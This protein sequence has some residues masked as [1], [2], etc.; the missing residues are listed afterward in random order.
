MDDIR[1]IGLKYE[2]M[3][4]KELQLM[5]DRNAKHWSV[6][7]GEFK[8]EYAWYDFEECGGIEVKFDEIADKSNRL[9]VDKHTDGKES[10]L[11][12]TR[13][14]WYVFFTNTRYYIIKAEILKFCC[15]YKDNIRYYSKNADKYL[16]T[17]V[18]HDEYF[19]SPVSG[20]IMDLYCIPIPL[21]EIFCDDS[22]L[23]EDFTI[24]VML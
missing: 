5:V 3:V 18:R 13:A 10:G 22:G 7:G 21:I 8:P 2:D 11:I 23:I 16:N 4:L 9:A 24:N 14:F 20:R 12:T 6:Y 17:R 19:K 15:D 1:E